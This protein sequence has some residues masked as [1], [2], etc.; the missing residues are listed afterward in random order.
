M[1][2]QL[3]R[4]SVAIL[5][6]GLAFQSYAQQEIRAEGGKW[7]ANNEV[8]NPEDNFKAKADYTNWRFPVEA[9]NQ[10][11]T[12]DRFVSF[13]YPD[14]SAQFVSSD[15]EANHYNWH[16]VGAVFTPNDP[17]LELEGDNIALSRYNEYTVD[18][19]YFPYLYVRYVDSADIAGTMTEVVDTLIVQFYRADQLESRSFTPQGS[20]PELFMK[21]GNWTQSLLGSNNTAYEMKIPL[22]GED[23]TGRPSTEGWSQGG[24]VVPLPPGFDIDSDAD[25]VELEFANAFGFSIS[26]KNMLPNNFGDTMEARDGS[27]VTNPVNY[28]GHS[29]FSN[30]SIEVKQT[31]YINN[32]WWVPSTIAYGAAQNGWENSVPG[33]AYF[34]D[35]YLNYGIHISTPYLSTE[36][37]E[38]VITYGVYPNPISASQTLMADFNLVNAGAVSIEM[39]DILGNKVKTVANDYFTSG[40]HKLDINISDLAPG[41]YIYTVK[42]GN[43]VSSKKVS[44]VEEYKS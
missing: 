34:D 42:A 29:F 7:K 30:S 8:S 32:S 16:S 25:N 24:R 23:S 37:V 40:E 26:Y 28:F 3:Q 22:K 4:I 43:A 18:S 38:N 31:E 2:K 9:I 21:P 17:N 11:T 12:L 6:V 13:L 19:I 27:P 1:K 5:F 36:D 33:N 35:R 20:D 10:L 44:I 41:M 14:S 15:G 39:F